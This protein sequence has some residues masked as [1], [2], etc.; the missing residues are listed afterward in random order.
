MLAIWV[1]NKDVEEMEVHHLAFQ[2][3]SNHGSKL[4]DALFESLHLCHSEFDVVCLQRHSGCMARG[5][6]IDLTSLN[7]L[8]Q[9]IG[10]SCGLGVRE[11]AL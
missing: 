8:T 4:S 10:I 9:M 6:T 7:S 11:V 1:L 2:T 5:W 3:P